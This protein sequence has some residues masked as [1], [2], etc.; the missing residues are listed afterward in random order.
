[1]R[2]RF[3]VLLLL[4]PAG[5]AP[6]WA[7]TDEEIFRDFRFN[8]INPGARSLALGGAFVSLAD[9]ATAAQANPAGMSFLDRTEVFAEVRSIDNAAQSSIRVETDLPGGIDTF[10]ATGTDLDDVVSPSFLSAVMNFNRWSVSISRQELLNIKNSTLSAFAFTF[11]DSPG[12]FLVEGSGFIDVDVTNINASAGFRIID[13]LSIG[14]TLTYSKLDA[15]TEVVNTFVDTGGTIAGQVVLQP[16]LDLRTSIDDDDDDFVYSLGIIYKEPE[17]WSVG[18]VYRKGPDFTVQEN[19]D[20]TGFDLFAV[21][22]RFPGQS[23][24]NRFN[25]PDVFG[26]GASWFFL[27]QRLTLALEIEHIL[28]S[29]LL[30]GYVAGVNVLTS[31][32]AEFDIDDA[33][34][35]RLG[36]EYAFVNADNA[37]P[38]LALRGGAYRQSAATI[39]AITT[40][41]P[42]QPGF[43]SS[44][45]FSGESAEYHGTIG[46]GIFLKRFQIDLAADF[47]D[48][49]NEYLVSFIYRGK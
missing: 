27:E 16:E 39:E 40:G 3:L 33:T 12:A 38:P 26:A 43:A 1:M 42:A 28:Y 22:N 29:N 8:L 35:Y 19:I 20:S 23:F 4:L 24:P 18:G 30:D 14:A 36:A 7:L 34:D 32:G 21:G 17:K 37:M 41:T 47:S 49:K 45:V 2:P 10:V 9:D 5:M 13:K 6:A 46:A 15:K 31:P 25:L 44:D 48:S 11:S